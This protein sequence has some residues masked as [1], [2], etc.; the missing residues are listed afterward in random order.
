MKSHARVVVIGG[1]IAGCSVLYHLVKMGWSDVVL[2]ERDEL[3]SGSTWHAAGNTPTFSTSYNIAKMQRYS[4]ELYHRLESETGQAVDAHRTGSL[5]LA[6]TPG[7]MD[8]FRRVV[9]LSHSMGLDLEL[10]ETKHIRDHHPFVNTE[11]ILGALYD[12]ADGHVDPSSVTQG[13]AKG[14]RDGGAE[15]YRKNPVESIER[16]TNGEW[17]VHTKKGPITAEILVNSAG[18]RAGEVA[19]MVGHSIPMV[20][21]EH[22]FVLT[23][24]IRDLEGREGILPLLREPD[25]SYYM[26]QEGQSLIVGPY[27]EDSRPWAVGGVPPAF[28]QELLP[29]D[30]DRIQ[31]IVEKAMKR[32]PILANA[33]IKSIVNGPITY[34]PDGG[35]LIGPEAGI[36]NYFLCTA[37]S[38]G[39]VQAGGAGKYT[40]QWIIEGEPEV[41]LWEADPRRYGPYATE[42]YCVERISDF[43][44]KEY[45]IGYPGEERPPGRPAKM[46]PIHDR[47][48]ARGAMFGAR[49]GWERPNWFV[50]KGS[51]AEDVLSFRRTNW[52]EPVGQECRAVRGRVGVLD[53]SGFSKFVVSGPGA[54]AYLER[55]SANRIPRKV[56]GIVLA[57]FLTERGGVACEFTITRQGPDRFYLV[58]AAFT[59][60]HDLDW[61]RDHLPDDG[62]VVVE[63]VTG[64]Y[65]TLIVVGPRSR[66][67][68]AK[69][70][71]ADLSNAAFPW[72]TGQKIE[73]G[74]AQA[75]ALRVNYVGELGWELHVPVAQMCPIYDALVAAGGEFG[76]A[77][78]GLR[79]MESLRLEK[80][81]RMWGLELTTE[82]TPLDAG[83][84]R[85]VKFE[86]RDF[87]GREALLRQRKEGLKQRLVCLE[88]QADD[89][90]AY[91]REPVYHGDEVVGMVSSGGYGH[92]LAKSIAL[93]YVPPGLAEAGTT[94]SVEILNRRCQATVLSETPYDPG[95]DRLRS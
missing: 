72:L 75:W 19:A 31:Y 56:G 20:S 85:F 7:R 3:S 42:R 46:S 34:T 94:L 32:V 57:H 38:F 5:R 4:I 22:Q 55:L 69:L 50:P 71:D 81:Y 10:I 77:D 95:N 83:L 51:K 64:A 61:L 8:E 67:L 30:L 14:A 40:A 80:A 82:Y 63:D 66:E 11:G 28:G 2:V 29:G 21:M 26:R 73:I 15:I 58:S 65:G 79:A 54:E 87:I 91:G 90:D 41:D 60:L 37:F 45:A 24:S 18:F 76:L 27:E 12:P 16:K 13:L 93:A 9:G 17:V 62:S 48:A 68:L 35:M 92:T 49:F 23:D 78:F 53:L 43:Y 52:F 47:L 33:G 6:N 36:S 74:F 88:V 84:E 25:I 59:E 44:S 86:G 1:G 39:I 70:T 89:A